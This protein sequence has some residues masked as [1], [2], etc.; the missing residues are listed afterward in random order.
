VFDRSGRYVRTIL[1][2]P[3]GMPASKLAGIRRLDAGG[4]FAPYLYQPETRSYLP[5]LGEL[6]S[7]RAVVTEDG[8]LAWI[9]NQ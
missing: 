2:F 7:Q 9:G 4:R 3:A 1:P 8:R 5:G 6:P